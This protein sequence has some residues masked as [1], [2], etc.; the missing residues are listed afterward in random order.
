MLAALVGAASAAL[1]RAPVG[2][3][4]GRRAA[5][6]GAAAAPFGPPAVLPARAADSAWAAHQ[7][8]FDFSSYQQSA[9]L[10]GF[11]YKKLRAGAGDRPVQFQQI[12]VHYVSYLPDGTRV[13]SSYGTGDGQPFA[14][15]ISAKGLGRGSRTT[16]DEKVI[17]GF[18]NVAVALQPG[19]RVVVKIPAEAAYGAAGS[20]DPPV[21]A[22][23]PLVC[24]LELVELGNIKGDKPRLNP[25]QNMSPD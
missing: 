23:S 18:E 13:D 22:N 3:P 20:T 25:D 17:T 12:F 9:A 24:F 5:V 15:R 7:G 11:T 6:A 16:N 21:P 10:P 14:F 19:A 2:G 8:A 4:V 1:V